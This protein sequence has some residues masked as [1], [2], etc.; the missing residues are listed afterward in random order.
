VAEVPV[1]TRLAGRSLA[2][3]STCVIAA[4]LAVEVIEELLGMRDAWFVAYLSLSYEA[5]VPTWYSAALLLGCAALL[6]MCAGAARRDGGPK[7]RWWLLAAG[8]LY[9][10]LDESVE[11]HE[12]AHFIHARGILYFSWVIPAAVLV[13]VIGAS[14]VR[15][16]LSLPRATRRR[17]V[18][19]GALFVTGALLLELP[20]GWWTERHGSDSF[21]YALIDWV[22][23]SLEIAGVS[24]FAWSLTT[25]LAERGVSL[26]FGAQEPATGPAGEA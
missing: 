4:G 17:F 14:Y 6:S 26:R 10:A 13:L 7:R 5:N 23:E 2:I 15:F 19:A 22:E 8:F 21:G 20:L 25:H 9:M 24:L 1:S 11:I 16:L 3:C 18:V 12:R